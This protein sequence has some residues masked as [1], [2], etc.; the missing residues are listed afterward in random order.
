MKK[1][2]RKLLSGFL[3][4]CMIAGMASSPASTVQA[5]DTQAA[6]SVVLGSAI[7]DDGSQTVFTYPH[8]TISHV[9]QAN[10]IYSLTVDV[11]NGQVE[12][13]EKG[14]L[15]IPLYGAKGNTYMYNNGKTVAEMTEII[16]SLKFTPNAGSHM[17]VNISISGNETS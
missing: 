10:K 13:S 8:A 9:E 17:D 14:D 7:W 11:E 5:E 6:Y 15:Q 3:S 16:R 1:I 12:V 2:G 4:L